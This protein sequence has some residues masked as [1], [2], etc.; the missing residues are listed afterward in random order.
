MTIERMLRVNHSGEVA[1]QAIYKAQLRVFRQGPTHHLL[2]E[3]LEQEQRHL[4]TFNEL[5]PK[6]QVRPSALLPLWQLCGSALGFTTVMSMVVDHRHLPDPKLQWLVLKLLKLSLAVI[7]MSNYIFMHS[8]VFSQIRELQSNVGT[9][10]E[11]LLK[12]IQ[13]FRDDE[14]QHQKTAIEQKSQETLG[15]GI[16]TFIIK[17]GCEAAIEIAKRV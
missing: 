14:L 2:K 15:H 10:D 4:T 7:T 16:L 3:M 9:K 12:I 11:G 8:F 17:R 1:A 5:L 6:Y 13:E